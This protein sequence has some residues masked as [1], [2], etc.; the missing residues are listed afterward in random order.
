M[1]LVRSPNHHVSAGCGGEVCRC[2]S[3]AAHKIAEEILFDDPMPERHPFTA[4]VCCACYVGLMGQWAGCSAERADL[5][6]LRSELA[7]AKA[8]V[9]GMREGIEHLRAM[10]VR[11][12]EERDSAEDFADRL[13]ARLERITEGGA[14]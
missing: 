13:M 11:I 6:Y 1:T 8:Q 14:K 10:V 12:S 7:H 4:M 3:P 9:Q 5:W 2:G